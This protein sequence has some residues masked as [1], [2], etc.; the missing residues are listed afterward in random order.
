MMKEFH[1]EL[2]QI[3]ESF[4]DHS[5]ENNDEKKIEPDNNKVEKIK[6]LVEEKEIP[7]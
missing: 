6:I 2:R 1:S 5:L 3:K 7:L 4:E